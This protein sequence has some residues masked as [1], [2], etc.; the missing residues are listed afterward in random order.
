MEKLSELKIRENLREKIKNIAI[1]TQ[2]EAKSTNEY[3]KQA[4][5]NG[6]CKENTVF[7]AESQTD[8]RG[9]LGR[10][11]FSPPGTGLYMSLA[12]K[13]RIEA[14]NVTAVTA[15]TAVAVCRA[16]ANCG[17][18][19][20]KIKW[21]NDIFNEQNK[22]VCGILCESVFSG[23]KKPDCVV[24]G[25]GI[26]LLE[27][28]NGFPENIKN[29]AGAVFNEKKEDLKNKV[30]AEFLNCFFDL[31][32]K[33][34]I[35]EIYEE[36]KKRCFV[37]GKT[38]NFNENNETVTAVAEKLDGNFALIVKTESGEYKRLF[39]GEISLMQG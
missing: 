24:V 12:I 30:A 22:K 25:V 18:G 7:C 39:F 28:E 13:P 5:L 19:E 4:F 27:P 32:E 33:F 36:Y 10:S 6:N 9:R 8:G 35:N 21:V 34:S 29:T 11:F 16:L 37:L 14:Q 38:V 15:L 20:L 2:D 3:I 26:N 17:S 23:G 31:Y 1:I